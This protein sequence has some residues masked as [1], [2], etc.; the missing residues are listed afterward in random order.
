MW[1]W[2]GEMGGGGGMKL[3]ERV[4]AGVGWGDDR[5]LEWEG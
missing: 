2:G 1:G 3:G 5:R 4:C